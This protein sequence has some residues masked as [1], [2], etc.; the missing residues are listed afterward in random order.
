MA[1]RKAYMPP[2]AGGQGFARTKKV[3]GGTY[4]IQATDVVAANTVSI[5]MI[6]AGFVVQ[7]IWGTFPDL[8]TGAT[9]T[10]SVGDALSPNRLVNAN[11]G[12]QTGAA[13]PAL[14][15]GAVGYQYPT[16]TEILMSFPAGPVG[17]TAGTGN[18][19]IEGF[20]SNFIY[21]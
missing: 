3:L 20:M 13:V 11:A 7:S 1:L 12:A 18:F 6:P 2:Q 19:Y 21:P 15:A 8:D 4:N 5:A 10:V 14:I 16:D 9:L 17:A